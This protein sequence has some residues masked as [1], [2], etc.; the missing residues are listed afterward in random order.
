[1]MTWRTC[2]SVITVMGNQSVSDIVLL[3]KTLTFG[4][5][6]SEIETNSGKVSKSITKI[7]EKESLM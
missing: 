6:K 5:V 2:I 3:E 4:E 1:M 7:A